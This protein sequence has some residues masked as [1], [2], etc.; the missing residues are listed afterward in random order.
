L[1]FT[2]VTALDATGHDLVDA[3]IGRG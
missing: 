1:G 3:S 2:K